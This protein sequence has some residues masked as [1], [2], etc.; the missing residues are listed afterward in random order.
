MLQ[1]APQLKVMSGLEL[2]LGQRRV[3]RRGPMAQDTAS[4]LGKLPARKNKD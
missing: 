3:P 1:E 4:G 2:A